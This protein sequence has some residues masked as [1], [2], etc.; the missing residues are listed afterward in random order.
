MC[1][2]QEV[3]FFVEL[4]SANKRLVSLGLDSILVLR[5]IKNDCE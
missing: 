1:T 2:L 5:E 4:G 3:S